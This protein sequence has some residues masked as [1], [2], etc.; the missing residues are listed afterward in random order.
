MDSVI[1]GNKLL[2]FTNIG[3]ESASDYE[4]LQKGKHTITCITKTKR[5]FYSIINIPG[6]GTGKK[7]IQID[8]INNFSFLE[9]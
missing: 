8:A 1:V 4:K 2:V 7:S 6:S 3:L 9:D 5:K